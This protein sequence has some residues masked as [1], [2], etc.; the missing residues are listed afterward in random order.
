MAGFV[1]G[2]SF[3]NPSGQPDEAWQTWYAS[4]SMLQPTV[5]ILSH[6]ASRDAPAT[7]RTGVA[8]FVGEDIALVITTTGGGFQYVDLDRRRDGIYYGP[9][10]PEPFVDFESRWV[11]IPNLGPQWTAAVPF[12]SP[13][14]PPENRFVR[15]DLV[16]GAEFESSGR[17]FLYGNRV[18]DTRSGKMRRAFDE[19]HR[20]ASS[21]DNRLVAVQRKPLA[22]SKSQASGE[23]IEV[24]DLESDRRLC[25]F[26]ATFLYGWT[27]SIHARWSL[28]AG[29]KLRWWHD[30]RI[31]GRWHSDRTSRGGNPIQTIGCR[32]IHREK[33]CWSWIQI[34]IQHPSEEALS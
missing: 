29:T 34:R 3:R 4:E 2:A 25:Q 19:Q 18:W 24:W 5:T 8:Q 11:S 12:L 31:R 15:T 13:T 22:S 33:S 32:S 21:S 27:M 7:N 28:F 17:W 14:Y 10:G 16:H 20:L 6:S 1:R 26:E 23:P 30:H 9:Q